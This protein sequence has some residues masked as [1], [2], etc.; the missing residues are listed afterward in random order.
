MC[1]MST[2]L[3]MNAVAS[4]EENKNEIRVH[5]EYKTVALR[6]FFS[7]VGIFQ[8]IPGYTFAMYIHVLSLWKATINRYGL[9]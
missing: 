1:Q 9:I 8:T 7:P 5:D 3:I 4:I 6:F 2:T